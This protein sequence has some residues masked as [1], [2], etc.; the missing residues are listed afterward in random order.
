M[1]ANPEW[2]QVLTAVEADAQRAAELLYGSIGSGAPAEALLPSALLPPLSEM[3][4]VPAHLRAR[5]EYLRSRIDELRG[6]LSDALRDWQPARLP[7][8]I[9]AAAPAERSF[10][11]DRRL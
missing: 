3:P 7:V 8:T 10:Y 1:A 6:E 4:A 11:V 9:T 5:I 2:E